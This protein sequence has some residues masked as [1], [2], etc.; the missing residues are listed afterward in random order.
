MC[1]FC[2]KFTFTFAVGKSHLPSGNGFSVSISDLP[3]D[4]FQLP[5][6]KTHLPSENL[7]CHQKI[8]FAVGKLH[9]S[10]GNGFSVSISDLPMD[11]FHLPSGNFIC[12]REM[13]FLLQFL[14]YQ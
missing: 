8:S 10:L 12:R 2:H 14:I 9:L 7:I 4:K 6:G 13:D 5:T 3:I 11:K 1:V